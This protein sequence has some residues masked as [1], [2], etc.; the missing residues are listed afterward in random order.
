MTCR[1]SWW[2]H[3]ISEG[4]MSSPACYHRW[5]CCDQQ[6]PWAHPRNEPLQRGF[7]GARYT[8]RAFGE[9]V[10]SSPSLLCNFIKADSYSYNLWLIGKLPL[11]VKSQGV[12]LS[13]RWYGHSGTQFPNHVVSAGIASFS[14]QNH[15]CLCI[16]VKCKTHQNNIETDREPRYLRNFL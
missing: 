6:T 15:V 9:V 16:V 8:G 12:E 10:L 7:T 13:I 4:Q 1:N 3:S 2:S 14:G 11:V 5:Q